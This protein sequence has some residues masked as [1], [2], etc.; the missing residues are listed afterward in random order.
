MRLHVHGALNNGL[1]PEEIRKVMMQ[2]AIDCAKPA[3]LD[4][5]KVGG[6]VLKEEGGIA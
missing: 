2:V 4:S 6:E 5:M 3:G 1:T